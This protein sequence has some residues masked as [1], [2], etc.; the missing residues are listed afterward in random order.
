MAGGLLNLA[1][2]GSQNVIM[3]GNPQKTYWTSTYKQITN[4]GI[5]NFR[6]DFEGQRKMSLTTDSIFTFKVK[7][8]A[9]LLTSTY[10]VM[11]LPDIYSPIYET[12]LLEDV[13][14]EVITYVCESCGT[15]NSC[16][17][18][19]GCCCCTFVQNSVITIV[20]TNVIKDRPYEF[21]WIKNI[22]AMMIRNIKFMIGGQL[23]Q[24][25]TGYDM[26]ALANRDLNETMKKKWDELIGN[27]PE[28]YDPAKLHDNRYP[29]AINFTTDETIPGGAEPSIRG[30]QLRVPLPIW[31]GLNSQQ[32]FPL[33][34]LQ[35]NELT[36]EVT[37]RPLSE[38]YQICNVTAN[39][40]L[41]EDV[42]E[43]I[44][45][46]MNND[47]HQFK[48][49]VN[50]P[51]KLPTFDT[52]T[53][54]TVFRPVVSPNYAWF[55]NIHLSCNYCFLSDDEAAL[56]AMNSQQYLIREIRDTWFNEVNFADKVWHQNT[57]GL[58]T[59]WM[60]LYQ[61]S[62][63]KT[64]NEWSN[65]TNWKFDKIPNEII[66]FSGINNSY[67]TD[68][69]RD[70]RGPLNQ[71]LY[72]TGEAHPENQKHILNT[73]G[74]RIDGEIREEIKPYSVY[75]G[76]QQYLAIPGMGNVSLPG[77]YCYNF[78]L[79]TDPFSLQPSGAMNLSK[80]GKIEFEFTTHTPSTNPDATYQVLCDP[81]T[82]IP[83]ETNKTVVQLYLYYYN[84]LV[85]EERYNILT[86][87]GGNAGMM[88]A[89]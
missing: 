83:I 74:I 72:I 42:T 8:Y 18:T 89:R 43:V 35:Y 47:A 1:S 33:V 68:F 21:K 29:N 73:L 62:D 34:C 37:L 25:M 65:F 39:T 45:P 3:Y 32:A 46:N 59:S 75:S 78:C 81:I 26:V 61:R 38:L 53:G 40:V 69:A 56:F 44:S 9:E 31:W 19:S 70:A 48:H 71:T 10:F 60:F 5:Q 79:K 86:F 63:V 20:P 49:F 23:I 24:Q 57:S 2:G 22:G 76:E 77:L 50:L 12:I 30:R 51:V 66:Q 15:N 80:H 16:T 14:T 67:D 52:L 88:N 87:V 55:E 7:R 64:R 82:G 85:V 27:V 28:L 4:F 41:G 11:D 84:L 58:V 54:D 6:L 13:D 17:D 36:I